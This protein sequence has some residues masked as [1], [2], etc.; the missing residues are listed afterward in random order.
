[1]PHADAHLACNL[2]RNPRWEMDELHEADTQPLD[3]DCQ[4]LHKGPGIYIFCC[5]G[6]ACVNVTV[7]YEKSWCGERR[8]PLHFCSEGGHIAAVNGG[9]DSGGVWIGL[10]RG[11]ASGV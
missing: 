10:L 5:I 11:I 3:G 6:F 1:M 2:R 7:E 9:F 4:I 8:A